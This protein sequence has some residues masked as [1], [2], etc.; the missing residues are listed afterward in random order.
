MNNII[1]ITNND[2]QALRFKKRKKSVCIKKSCSIPF[3]HKAVINGIIVDNDE[4]QNKLGLL[5]NRDSSYFKKFA[6]IVD[7]NEISVKNISAPSAARSQFKPLVEND[8]KAAGLTEDLICEYKVLNKSGNKSELLC[9]ATS[10]K[11]IEHYIELFNNINVNLK[12]IQ[13]G[14]ES[15]IRFVSNSLKGAEGTNLINIA[16][17]PTMLTIIFNKDKFVFST[18][19]RI[20][21]DSLEEYTE[22]ILRELSNMTQFCNSQ[23]TPPINASYYINV[24][25]EVLDNVKSEFT[26]FT[27]EKYPFNYKIKGK[28]IDKSL[29][30][31]GMFVAAAPENELCLLKA[32]KRKIKEQKEN[33]KKFKLTYLMYPALAVVLVSIYLFL[34]MD[35]N[36]INEQIKQKKDYINE[37]SIATVVNEYDNLQ[38]QIEALRSKQ[39]DIDSVIAATDKS[40]AFTSDILNLIFNTAGKDVSIST[41]KY[42]ED[43]SQ[44]DIECSAVNQLAV[45]SYVNNLRLS[46]HF[47]DIVYQGYNK[48]E[49]RYN[50]SV[51]IIIKAKEGGSV[52]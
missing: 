50:F 52:K 4:V 12:N 47:S 23:N 39:G 27:V 42:T 35:S 8:F 7:S 1:I 25:E 26:T 3:D 28:S 24:P 31:L 38:S 30:A 40:Y 18:R 29:F 44:I 5:K 22:Y 45:S 51:S 11:L 14:M 49:K 34:K 48:S 16:D 33:K 19:T 21:S 13:V 10:Y 9:A 17:G 37:A 20:L 15:V 32:Y 36:S 43:V 2:I 6:L 46:D 41:I